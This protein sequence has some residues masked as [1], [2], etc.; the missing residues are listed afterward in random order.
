MNAVSTSRFSLKRLASHARSSIC[1]YMNRLAR[2]HFFEPHAQLSV[3]SSKH[4]M[5]IEPTIPSSESPPSLPEVE[6]DS[7]SDSSDFLETLTRLFDF[8][9]VKMKNEKRYVNMDNL[10][11]S[12][13]SFDDNDL[14]E[15]TLVPLMHTAKPCITAIIDIPESMLALQ[16]D[17]EKDRCNDDAYELDKDD[18]V[19]KQ[20]IL[21]W[22]KGVKDRCLLRR[23][24]ES[25]DD[26]YQAMMK[27]YSDCFEK[28]SKATGVDLGE[29]YFTED[30]KAI[31]A[32]FYE[33]TDDFK[34][35]RR[36][37]CF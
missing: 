20:H 5:P 14:V 36:V 28:V 4:P 13:N 1:R 27:D 11:P 30:A 24:I 8:T 10:G 31:C 26:L 9:L 2:R 12:A 15:D 18:L 32:R 6:G 34:A 33:L 35:R 25:M 16:P 37:H 17:D 23:A 7:G 21:G 3:K 29:F 22:Y 19:N